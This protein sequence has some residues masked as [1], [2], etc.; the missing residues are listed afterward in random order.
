MF[1][2]ELYSTACLANGYFCPSTNSGLEQGQASILQA[3]SFIIIFSTVLAPPYTHIQQRV[4]PQP[5]LCKR[6]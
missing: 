4:Q 5:C 6:Q 2:L 3:E 1:C